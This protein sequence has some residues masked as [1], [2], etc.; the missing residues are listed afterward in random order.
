MGPMCFDY[1]FGPFRWVCCSGE[2]ADLEK[3]DLIAAK[4]L[5]EML[6]EAPDEIKGQIRDNLNWIRDA[7]VNLPV[8][9][10][11]SR[12]CTPIPKAGCASPRRSMTPLPAAN[13]RVRWYWGAI[14]TT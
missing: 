14:T 3:T 6:P 4:V 12:I 11:M 13:Y 9:G 1:G 8:V 5:A 2:I 7:K 10:S